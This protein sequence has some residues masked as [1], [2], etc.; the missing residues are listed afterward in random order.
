MAGDHQSM[1]ISSD[2]LQELLICDICAEPYDNKTRQAR[3]LEC[4]HTFCSQCLFLLAR[5]GRE[6]PNTLRCPNCRQPTHLPGKGVHGLSANFFVEKLK[7]IYATADKTKD[8]PSME[9]CP[10]HHNQTIYFYCE[11]CSTAICRDCTVVDHDKTAGHSIVN[12]ADAVVAQQHVLK[13]QIHASRGIRSR[14]QRAIRQV[15]SGVEKLY[16]CRDAVVND[17]RS[18]IQDAH[19]QLDQG[20]QVISSLITQQCEI[21]QSH[22]LDKKVVFQQ[23]HELLDKHIG[24]CEVLVKKGDINEMKNV[25]DKLTM[26]TEIAQLDTATFEKYLPTDMITDATS[27][28]NSVC[29]LGKKCFKSFLPTKLILKNAMFIAGFK[30]TLAIDL[31]NDEGSK[32]PI[33]ACFLS[34][35]ITDPWETELPVTLNT[36]DP[37]LTVTFTPQRSGRHD[38][39]VMYLGQEL[40]ND[41]NHVSVEGNNPVLKIGGPGDGNGTFKSPRGIAIDNNNCLYVA[42]TGNGLIQKFTAEGEF[43][44]QFPVN[45]HDRSYT[46]FDV[47]LDLNKGLII[48]TETWMVN[49]LATKGDTMLHFNFKGE[50]QNTYALS[51]MSCPLGISVTSHGNVLLSDE[52]EKCVFEVDAEGEFLKQMGNFGRSGYICVNDDGS[53]IVPDRDRRSITIFDPD[54]N[55]K[56]QFGAHGSGKGQLNN[57]FAVAT[58]GENILVTEPGNN[59]AQVFRYDGTPVCVIESPKDPLRE[60]RGLAVTQDGY[61]YVVDRNNHC[62]KKYKYRDIAW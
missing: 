3:F 18:V 52:E 8:V 51:G 48:C 11:T 17:L 31:L 34:I 50:L 15:E 54:W 14:I 32:V 42:D 45:A 13:Q 33:A 62:I 24:Q 38:I 4:H 1:S 9:G 29:D 58:D 39:T 60:P 23:A 36:T 26:A 30:S 44:S 7:S 6:N 59:R 46:A 19:K 41:Q 16:V 2:E 57:P 47:A 21:Q 53:I 25:V 49:N 56:H 28:N 22:F 20:E 61:V 10:N 40:R 35:K 37:E 12:I 43:L 27:L 5:K 55:V